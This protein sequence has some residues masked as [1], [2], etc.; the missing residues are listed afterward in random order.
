M[1]ETETKS[2]VDEKGV[3]WSESKMGAQNDL[4]LQSDGEKCNCSGKGLDG[5]QDSI[6]YVYALGKLSFRFP[7][8]VCR[9]GTGSSYR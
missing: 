6:S 7:N 8:K 9:K 2:R 4:S 1:N 5:I 3:G